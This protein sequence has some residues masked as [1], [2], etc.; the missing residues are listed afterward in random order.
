MIRLAI[1]VE[2]QTEEAF[3]KDLLADPLLERNVAPCPILIG[4]AQSGG[5]GGGGVDVA[6]LVS[7][8]VGL[9]SSYDAVTSLVDFY[10]FRDK[11]SR[12]V[13][14]LEKHLA[15]EIGKRI[16]H[17]RWMF[18]YVQKHEFEGLLFSDARAFRAILQA[19]ARDA[20][21]LVALRRRFTTPEDIN[22]DP[23]GA[24]SKRIANMLS[25]YRKRLHGPLVARKTG[26]DAIRAECPRF[27][28]WLTRLEGL[29]RLK[30]SN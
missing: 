19:T 22:D 15:R 18:P 30:H 8:M 3:V 25:G 2:G 9:H 23:N 28:A 7:D 21:A 10:G 12:T 29:A 6:R 5:R 26:L 1:V 20:K 4:R 17:T 11:G 13:E 24:P 16:P 14:A 27:D